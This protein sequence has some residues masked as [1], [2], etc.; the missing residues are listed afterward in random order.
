MISGYFGQKDTFDQAI[1]HFAVAY[2]DQT[3]QDYQKLVVAVK[4]GRL[5]AIQE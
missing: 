1:A 4:A 5:S 3:E 2:A